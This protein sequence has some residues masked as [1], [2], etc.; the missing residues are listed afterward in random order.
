MW[1]SDLMHES[2]G[3]AFEVKLE[4][5][6]KVNVR[7]SVFCGVQHVASGVQVAAIHLLQVWMY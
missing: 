3:S 4:V 6:T 5:F 7:I 2:G 1:Y